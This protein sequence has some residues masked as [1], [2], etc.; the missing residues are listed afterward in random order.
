[1][2]AVAGIAVKLNL[3]GQCGG[4]DGVPLLGSDMS[5]ATFQIIDSS[6]LPR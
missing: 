3:L 6:T 1:M 2:E 5:I 4:K